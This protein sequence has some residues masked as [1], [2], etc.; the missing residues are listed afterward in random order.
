MAGF[1]MTEAAAAFLAATPTGVGQIAAVTIQLGLA[2]FGAVGLVQAGV[3]TLEHATEWLTLAWTARGKESQVAAASRAFLKMLVLPSM[4]A[5]LYLGIKGNMGK[6]VVI[7]DRGPPMPPAYALA[8]GRQIGG[9]GSAVATGLGRS[10]G[11]SR[12]PM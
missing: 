8:G 2:A 3:V 12:C 1:I 6:A 10:A 11:P 5:L 4:A 7:A 9:T